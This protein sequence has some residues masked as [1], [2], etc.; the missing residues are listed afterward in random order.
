MR[1][2]C[3]A[4]PPRE[5]AGGIPML[6]EFGQYV[7][8]VVQIPL[9]REREPRGL[10]EVRRCAVSSSRGIQPM[11]AA[12]VFS[13]GSPWSGAPPGRYPSSR[14][15]AATCSG[16]SGA[17]A[18]CAGGPMSASRRAAPPPFRRSRG[19]RRRMPCLGAL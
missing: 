14:R 8:F 9:L 4:A 6:P 12:R 17:C 11:V 10:M 7:M 1:A 5:R 19:G 13:A 18:S 16:G 3:G 15:S 2:T